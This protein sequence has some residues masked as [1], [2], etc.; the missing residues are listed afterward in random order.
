VSVLDT[1]RVYFRGQMTWDPI[2]TNNYRQFYDR[3]AG[4][5]ILGTG[6]AGDYRERAR[7]SI[8]QGNWNLHGTHRSTLFETTVSG[9]DRGHGLE[10]DDA[11]VGVPVS[12]TGMLV[13][14]D[15]YGASTSQLFF[16]DL[17]CGI[18]GGSQI[19]APRAGPMVA[20]RVNFARN[21]TYAYIAG[22]ASVVWQTSFPADGGLSVQSRGSAV[23]DAL[24]AVLADDDTLGLTVRMNAYRT[25]Y[26]DT[27]D[28]TDQQAADL[29]DRIAQG[30]F[31]P[32]PARSMIVGVIG[33]WRKAEPSSVP[34]DRVVARAEGSSV[35]TAFAKLGDHRLTLDLGNSVP[36]TGFDLQKLNLGPLKVVAKSAG[37]QV[38]LGTL[39][40][41]SYDAGAYTATSGIVD[42]ALDEAQAAIA[43]TADLEVRTQDGN[44]VLVE[45]P[46]TAFADIPNVYLEEGE[47]ATVGLRVLERGG[48]PSS[49]VSIS[50]VQLGGPTPPAELHTDD[51]GV[52]T[53]PL[54]GGSAGSWTWFLVPWRGQAPS[55]S[56]GL[57]PDV[58]EYLA[59]R[60][61]PADAQIAA[62]EPTWENVHE[63]VLRDWEALAPCMDNWLRLGDEAQC[64][65]Y[66]G[67]I[68]KLTSRDRF[69]DFRYMPVT[70]E[71][72]RGQ[73][74]LLHRWCDAVTGVPPATLAS[75]EVS[76]TPK[77]SNP[78]SR[79]F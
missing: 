11:L 48:R 49:P 52:V 50:M 8:T 68:R 33:P 3:A 20:R 35:S 74:A 44:P 47:A 22:V 27:E 66:A 61:S 75:T 6:T 63:H 71:L 42:L 15:P 4:K 46:L 16:D 76:A 34:G 10:V 67:L 70:R 30:G 28:P 14:L 36:E 5:P 40:Y 43:R 56:A 38:E 23:L 29:A 77:E 78:F 21:T 73:R 69:E 64:K 13:D 58:S 32:N 57:V 12:F 41:S 79:G 51:E 37:A 9:V 55:P 1:P 2:V 62:M 45:Q 54:T 31:H 72:T 24:G 7:R 26:F 25:V 65:A 60:T 53:L 39:D 18:E 17:S 59:L 19:L